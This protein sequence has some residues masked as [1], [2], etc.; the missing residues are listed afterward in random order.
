MSM[1]RQ[2]VTSRRV[3]SYDRTGGGDDFIHIANGEKKIILDV[4]GAG[5]IDVELLAPA[6][7]VLA[8]LSIVTVVQRIWHV[9]QQL[10]ATA[11]AT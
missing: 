9:R 1:M 3:S 10:I 11:P 8:A 2:G 5:I 7:Y 6:V 4:K